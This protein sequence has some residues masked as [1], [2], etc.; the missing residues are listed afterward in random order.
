MQFKN[1]VSQHKLSCKLNKN[2]WFYT[3]IK[4]IQFIIVSTFVISITIVTFK[5]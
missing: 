2:D 5:F 3:Q 4:K 1:P